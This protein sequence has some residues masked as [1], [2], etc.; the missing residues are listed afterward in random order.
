MDSADSRGVLARVG[1]AFKTALS[2]AGAAPSPAEL[3]QLAHV[4][5]STMSDQG[6]FYH[7]TEHVFDL[8]STADAD[9]LA[10]LAALFHDTVCGAAVRV[11]DSP[12]A[13]VLRVGQP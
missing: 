5:H 9:P 10:T 12:H 3:E 4:V 6:R 11:R 2:L 7:R 13:A 8:F 1:E